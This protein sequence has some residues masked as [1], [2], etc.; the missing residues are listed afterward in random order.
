MYINCEVPVAFLNRSSQQRI[1]HSVRIRRR[2][3]WFIILSFHTWH[4]RHPHKRGPDFVTMAYPNPREAP[5]EF[6]EHLKSSNLGIAVTA[7]LHY[8]IRP[9][10]A[11]NGRFDEG[12][13]QEWCER[14]DTLLVS[15]IQSNYFIQKKL[16]TSRENSIASR[17]R[18][19]ITRT[20]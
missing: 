11:P 20:L 5:K 19:R 17:V 4:S 9:T 15:S 1:S 2:V 12:T 7:F 16:T 3:V 6:L 10:V 13:A 14:M 18:N 8:Q